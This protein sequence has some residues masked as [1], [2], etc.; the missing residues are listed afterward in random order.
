[1]IV[2][3]PRQKGF[4]LIEMMVTVIVASVLL[5][6]A[7]P[8]FRDMIRRNQVTSASNALLA[9]LSYA[10]TEAITRGNVVSICPSSDGSTCADDTTYDAGWLV[11]SYKP[12]QG[13]VATAYDDGD[14]NNL[15]LRST[16]A[17]SNVSMQAAAK[18]IVS[19]GPQGQARPSA[20]TYTFDTCFRPKGTTGH[21]ES[22][23]AVS[24]TRLSINASGGVSSTALAAGA[25]CAP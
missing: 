7:V 25:G 14:T 23:A 1:M 20:S 6:I 22:T 4:T 13:E 2:A 17:R 18:N 10:R 15:L 5:A 21:G 9:D 11:Y 12:G 8:S 3:D 19:F 16:G 24:G